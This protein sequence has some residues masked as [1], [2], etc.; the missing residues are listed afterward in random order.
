M[1]IRPTRLGK[2][3]L[4]ARIA[5]GGMA[6]IFLARQHSS[7]TGTLPPGLGL[8]RLAVVK[9]IL[10]HLAEEQTFIEMFLEEARYASMITHPNV[11]QIYDFGESEGEFYIAME[12]IDGPSIGLLARDARRLEQPLPPVIAAE[13]VAQAADGL[14]AAHELRDEEGLPLGLV[15]RDV[16]PHNLML[17][18]GGTIKLL[19][20]GVAKAQD[21][22][23]QTN[24]GSVK[25]KFPYM[26]PEQCRGDELD[27]RTDVF[28]LGIVFWEL[29]CAE[30]LFQRGTDLMT[31]KAIT[32]DPLPVPRD[33]NPA[34]PESLSEVLRR[35][36]ARDREARFSS[37]A[38]L[39]QA[40]RGALTGLGERG[41]AELLANYISERYGDDMDNRAAKL[42]EVSRKPTGAQVPV[43]RG[44]DHSRGRGS[45]VGSQRSASGMVNLGSQSGA[46][47][48]VQTGSDIVDLTSMPSGIYTVDERPPRTE[49]NPGA[50]K[51]RLWIWLAIATVLSGLSA[52]L[53]YRFALAPPTRPS[54]PALHFGMAPVF[55]KG[56]LKRQQQFGDLLRYLERSVERRVELAIA[57]TYADLP[58]RLV[59]GD[60]ALASISPLQFVR[61]RAAHPE[62]PML[63]AMINEG[64]STYQA[65][66]LVRS[67]SE[68]KKLADVRG[69][70]ICFVDRGSA[71][72]YLMPRYYLRKKGFDPEQDFSAIVLS[73]SHE[74]VLRDL[75]AGKC[76]IGATFSE[77]YRS[78]RKLKIPSS[79]LKIFRTTADLPLDVVCASPK[80][81]PQLR[82]KLKE[83][84]LAFVPQQH[85]GRSVVSDL[86]PITR[87]VT[88]RS[89]PFEALRAA[90][91]SEKKAKRDK[92]GAR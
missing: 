35:S 56:S 67:D 91:E 78:A 90:D 76:D 38:E 9:R 11:V 55:A 71:S 32:E 73:G 3:E 6:E 28:S 12:Y 5:K 42:R 49:T 62:V 37:A 44:F 58:R 33:R 27:R 15:H 13:I 82:Q 57:K 30:R 31:L 59:S 85:I 88:P 20:F 87:F 89:K 80:L 8:S 52:G 26:S 41:G 17:T 25:G 72:G 16:S 84:L 68:I 19:D 51:R 18:R 29:C 69:K 22:A 36:L 66:L 45:E 92:Q 75:V 23:V 39:A 46:R 54:G 61:M 4:L 50:R 1:D 74:Q 47:Q 64:S 79:A 83:A 2:F 48:H 70:R 24:T 43:V 34:L 86:Y 81:S 10:P 53:V 21:S 65:Y 7:E 77:A 63:A 40:V 60:I 14:Q